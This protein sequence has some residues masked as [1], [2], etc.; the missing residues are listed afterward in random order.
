M[1]I[2]L[3]LLFLV[4]T[5]PAFTFAYFDETDSIFAEADYQSDEWWAPSR[6]A[7]IYSQKYQSA[8][9]MASKMEEDDPFRL[10]GD[11]VPIDY[12]L[13]LTPFIEP[14][15]FTTL[16]FVAINVECINDTNSIVINAADLEINLETI[17]VSAIIDKF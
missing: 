5:I 4:S 8:L 11:V 6:K 3:Y 1:K 9:K 17:L 15:N 7:S 2:A 12:L 14:G 16:G 10:P 13:Q